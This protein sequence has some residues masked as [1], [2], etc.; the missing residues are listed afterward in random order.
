M[1][2]DFDAE[3]AHAEAYWSGGGV[4]TWSRHADE[5]CRLGRRKCSDFR[6]SDSV[7]GPRD[8]ARRRGRSRFVRSLLSRSPR[9]R[10]LFWHGDAQL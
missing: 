1:I 5:R 3:K 6:A 8:M 10:L 4:E 2:Y 7:T 9:A